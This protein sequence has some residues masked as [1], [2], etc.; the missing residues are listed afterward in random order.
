[1]FAMP[2]EGNSSPSP[3]NHPQ[4]PLGWLAYLYASI[5]PAARRDEFLVRRFL[6]IIAKTRRDPNAQCP[7]CGAKPN[8]LARML[9]AILPRGLAAHYSSGEI[10]WAEAF[11]GKSGKPGAILHRCKVCNAAWGDPPIMAFEDWKITLK[12]QE[13]HG[14]FGDDAKTIRS[15]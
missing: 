9:I 14:L 6:K 5:L 2:P 3:N 1:M 7:A 4:V 15:A 12:P 13:E 10:R 11:A 8:L